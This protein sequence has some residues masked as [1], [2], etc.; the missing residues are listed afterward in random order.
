[1]V[2]PIKER[3]LNTYN[4]LHTPFEF[5]E[6]GICDFLQNLTPLQHVKAI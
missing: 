2:K 4:S 6:K 3:N 5:D 1:M